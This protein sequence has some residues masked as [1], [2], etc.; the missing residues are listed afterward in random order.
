MRNKIDWT[1]EV[2]AEIDTRSLR[3]YREEQVEIKINATRTLSQL[4]PPEW[5]ADW[6][7]VF[8]SDIAQCDRIIAIIEAELTARGMPFE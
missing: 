3:I 1:P 6:R 4:T 8:I 2:A 5:F 7:G